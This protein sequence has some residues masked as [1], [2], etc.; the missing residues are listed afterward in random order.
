MFLQR[1]LVRH[2]QV[3]TKYPRVPRRTVTR[4]TRAKVIRITHQH[5]AIFRPY[6][7]VD[8]VLLDI[9][10]NLRSASCVCACVCVCLERLNR[11]KRM[12]GK[13]NRF[14]VRGLLLIRI[15]FSLSCSLIFQEHRFSI[16]DNNLFSRSIADA[17]LVWSVFVMEH[18]VSWLINR[19][20]FL[21]RLISLLANGMKS[22]TNVSPRQTMTQIVEIKAL[23]S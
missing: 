2:S 21:S 7:A 20:W 22:K 9:E 4:N 6:P 17:R 10:D 18:R 14:F 8:T 13:V 5:H 1:E 12:K 16:S 3:I 11:E 15:L 19:K 23:V